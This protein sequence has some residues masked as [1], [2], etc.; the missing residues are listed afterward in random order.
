MDLLQLNS[1]THTQT[2]LTVGILIGSQAITGCRQKLRNRKL[3]QTM[4]EKQPQ[5][6]KGKYTNAENVEC[7]L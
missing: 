5:T 6:N 3:Q 4:D 7:Q 1:N 2:G